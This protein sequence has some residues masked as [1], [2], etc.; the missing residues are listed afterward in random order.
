MSYRRKQNSI[1]SGI[2]QTLLLGVVLGIV[3]FSLDNDQPASAVKLTQSA[4]I[5]TAPPKFVPTREATQPAPVIATP[6]APPEPTTVFIPTVGVH[7]SIIE[8]YLDG[9]SWDV[10][11]LGTNA[12]HLQGT[13]SFEQPGNVVLAGHVELSDGRRGVFAR[14][15]EVS[16]GD[17]IIV[18]QGDEDRHYI[19]RAVQTTSADDLSVLY[20]TTNDQLTLITCDSYDFLQDVYLERIVVIAERIA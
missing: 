20:P 13:S 2:L 17:P 7:T 3:F 9:T 11:H 10:T 1:F 16:V 12:G 19:V 18:E 4:P 14:I 8:A 6:D 5:V 15:G